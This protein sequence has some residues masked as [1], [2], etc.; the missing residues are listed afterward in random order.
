MSFESPTTNNVLELLRI[1]SADARIGM[2]P[3]PHTVAEYNYGGLRMLG[4][5]NP[6]EGTEPQA[7]CNPNH[8][9]Q[10]HA[11]SVGVI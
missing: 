8:M 9:S 11:S 10:E 6:V 4:Q 3:I 2:P 5:K 1:N 7:M